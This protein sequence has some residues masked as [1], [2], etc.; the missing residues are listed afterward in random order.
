VALVAAGLRAGQ[1]LAAVLLYRLASFWLA[2]FTGWLVLL[3]LR[4]ATGTR[5]AGQDT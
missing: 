3:W 1:A 2:A 5:L 4:R